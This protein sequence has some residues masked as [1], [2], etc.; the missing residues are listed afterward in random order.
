M[1][2]PDSGIG[3]VLLIAFGGPEK[4]ED[5]MPFLR[6]VTRGRRIPD[7]RLEEVAHHYELFGGKSPLNELTFHQ[8][9]ALEEKLAELGHPL[10]VYVGM[11]NW[12]PFIAETLGKM[13]EARIRVALGLILAAHQSDSS[14]EQYQ[15][16][17]TRG[18]EEARVSMRIDFPG[19]TF[20]HPGFIEAM[21]DSV[22]A[23]FRKLRPDQHN[24]TSLLF[25]AHSIP[26]QDPHQSRYVK[27]L[28]TSCRKVAAA[29]QHP[30]WMLCYQ[31]RSGRPR[32]PWLEPDVN[33]AIRLQADRGAKAIIVAPI[34]FLTDHIEVLYDLD[35]EAAATAREAGVRMLR[36]G[37]VCDHPRFIDALADR[38]VAQIA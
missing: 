29:I 23:C 27:Q 17:V 15:R 32:D 14:W 10:P 19:P 3:G 13:G 6:H 26:I 37:T 7:E 22:G 20:D 9:R 21:A 11:R 4:Q 35:T 1:T 18:L 24:E 2:D 8:A 30:R 31:S 28:N 25:T 12:H 38:V 33:D 5:V 34:G 16:D 36:A